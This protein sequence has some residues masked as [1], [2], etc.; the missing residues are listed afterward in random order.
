MIIKI[1]A[2]AVL[3]YTSLA[4]IVLA[5]AVLECTITEAAQCHSSIPFLGISVTVAKGENQ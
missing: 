5:G 2:W 3:L 4:V 1:L